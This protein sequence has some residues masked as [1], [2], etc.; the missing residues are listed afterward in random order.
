MEINA[1]IFF[2][3]NANYL[4]IHLKL[5]CDKSYDVIQQK[6]LKDTI[7]KAKMMALKT[8]KAISTIKNNVHISCPLN[9]IALG[10]FPQL[11][12]KNKP[13]LF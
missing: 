12:K 7:E 10:T 6:K 9:Y 1:F 2:G 11:T 4:H 5:S 3:L 8:E 13:N